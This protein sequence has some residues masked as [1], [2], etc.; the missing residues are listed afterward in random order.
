MTKEDFAAR[1]EILIA[2]AQDEELSCEEIIA[3]LRG[4]PLACWTSSCP[5][6]TQAPGRG[7]LDRD[8]Y[9]RGSDTPFRRCRVGAMLGVRYGGTGPGKR[10]LSL[11]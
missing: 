9:A 6:A 5:E 2:D 1:L 11:N 3:S 10:A 7:R 8:R 4:A